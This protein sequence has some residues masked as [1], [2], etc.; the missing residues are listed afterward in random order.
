M[1]IFT[2]EEGAIPA[3]SFSPTGKKNQGKLACEPLVQGEDYALSYLDSQME[4]PWPLSEVQREP[5]YCVKF[6]LENTSDQ[7]RNY[8]LAVTAINGKPCTYIDCGTLVPGCS[9]VIYIEADYRSLGLSG[10]V[11]QN[12]T[13][14]LD[15]QDNF[16]EPIAWEEG[17]VYPD[18]QLPQ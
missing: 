16:G 7:R 2:M 12:V 13:L 3:Y 8:S 9:T 18:F 4:G 6:V 5:C 11:V 17:T 14:E 1:L 15:W 10:K